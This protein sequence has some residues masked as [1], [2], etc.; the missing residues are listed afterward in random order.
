MRYCI[1][2][3]GVDSGLERIVSII[4]YPNGT[5]LTTEIN[6]EYGNLACR[7]KILEGSCV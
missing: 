6:A 2:E 1:H 7:S 3:A 4:M 5:D